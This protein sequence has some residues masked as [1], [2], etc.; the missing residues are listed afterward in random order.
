VPNYNHSGKPGVIA[1][2]KG[3]LPNARYAVPLSEGILLRDAEEAYEL[4][5]KAEDLAHV[6]YL[7][8]VRRIPQPSYLTAWGN[9]SDEAWKTM[10]GAQ[11]P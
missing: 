1:I 7:E 9:D 5:L 8:A 6:K 4:L 10:M 3:T 2:E 11:L